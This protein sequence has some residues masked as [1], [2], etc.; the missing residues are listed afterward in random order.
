MPALLES[1]IKR[2]ELPS[3]I[4]PEILQGAIKAL[5][6]GGISWAG[7]FSALKI[8][9]WGEVAQ[10]EVVKSWAQRRKA[11]RI[12]S[13]ILKGIGLYDPLVLNTF[14][15]E[16]DILD[17]LKENQYS[18]WYTAFG[19]CIRNYKGLYNHKL[20]RVFYFSEY[21]PEILPIRFGRQLRRYIPRKDFPLMINQNG[22]TTN[23]GY[24]YEQL[25]R[26]YGVTIAGAKHIFGPGS[27]IRT[28]LDNNG[29]CYI[30][31]QNCCKD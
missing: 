25:S 30:R 19:A 24:S 5:Q 31:S 28:L 17:T 18:V 4:N 7:V 15:S 11:P 16:E 20:S 12:A 9:E 26:M 1:S 27:K 14:R 6:G 2:W 23:E 29:I 3:E 21:L 8:L 22:E 13:E 10:A